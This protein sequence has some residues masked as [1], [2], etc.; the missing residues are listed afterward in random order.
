MSDLTRGG[1]RP[2]QVG[3]PGK[4]PYKRGVTWIFAVV[5]GGGGGGRA[6]G[7][8][9]GG[10]AGGGRVRVCVGGARGGEG[11]GFSWE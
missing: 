9:G 6:G 5:G 11:E 2:H 4:K 1:V 10:G 8:R 3:G 7:G